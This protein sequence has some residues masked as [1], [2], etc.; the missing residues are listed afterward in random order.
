MNATATFQTTNADRHLTALITHFSKRVAAHQTGRVGHIALPFGHCNLA[1][2]DAQLSMIA[3]A[4]DTLNLD[5]VIEVM[6]RHL[7]RFA[8]RENPCLDWTVLPHPQPETSLK[9]L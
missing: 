3:T 2:N 5:H 4:A 6:T 9:E 7:E 8:F 1:A